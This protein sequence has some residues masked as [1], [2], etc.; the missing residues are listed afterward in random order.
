[1]A[2]KNAVRSWEFRAPKGALVSILHCV[3]TVRAFVDNTGYLFDSEGC[4]VSG[5]LVGKQIQSEEAKQD[6]KTE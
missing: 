4:R 2:V 1:V 6:T 5:Y 3:P